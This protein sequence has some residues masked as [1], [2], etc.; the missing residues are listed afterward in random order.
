MK[1]VIAK[2]PSDTIVE[3][4]VKGITLSQQASS[5]LDEI[6]LTKRE[7]TF[8]DFATLASLF[9]NTDASFWETLQKNWDM[10]EDK[11]CPDMSVMKESILEGLNF[12]KE[13]GQPFK[14][15]VLGLEKPLVCMTEQS[16]NHMLYNCVENDLHDL[17]WVGSSE[18]FAQKKEISPKLQSLLQQEKKKQEDLYTPFAKE[19]ISSVKDFLSKNPGHVLS[20]Q[21]IDIMEFLK[22]NPTLLTKE[23]LNTLEPTHHLKGD[24][25]VIFSVVD[26]ILILLLTENHTVGFVLLDKNYLVPLSKPRY[27]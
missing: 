14:I 18:K 5:Y 20:E 6:I 13:T 15:Q 21:A 9:E 23:F 2:H 17:G 24:D 11:P 1:T 25:S 10:V 3:F 16:Y 12:L 22:D 27:S 7:L 19:I 26:N 8:A 4:L